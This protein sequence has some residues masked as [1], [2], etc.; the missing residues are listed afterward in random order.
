[1]SMVSMESSSVIGGLLEEMGKA[2]ERLDDASR[3]LAAQLEPVLLAQDT[4]PANLKEEA[5]QC[6]ATSVI[7]RDL[8]AKVG[9]VKAVT[10]T[11]TDLREHLEI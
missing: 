6:P 8:A 1:M 5:V 9:L 3:Q 10:A 2:L 4:A 11:L 7:G